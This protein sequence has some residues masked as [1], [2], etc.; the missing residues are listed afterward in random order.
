MKYSYFPTDCKDIIL[1]LIHFIDHLQIS[2][3]GRCLPIMAAREADLSVPSLSLSFSGICAT[4]DLTSALK[5]KAAFAQTSQSNCCSSSGQAV[6]KAGIMEELKY[7][8]MP[9]LLSKETC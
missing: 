8:S 7:N 1:K 6:V 5:A 3:L 2:T 9:A 4:P